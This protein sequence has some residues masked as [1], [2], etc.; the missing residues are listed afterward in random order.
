MTVRE[1]LEMGAYSRHAWKQRAETMEQVC[2]IFPRLKERENP[3]R[4]HL[5][6]WRKADGRHRPWSHVKAKVVYL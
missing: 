1:N 4:K 6:W 2:Q 3:D 5:K